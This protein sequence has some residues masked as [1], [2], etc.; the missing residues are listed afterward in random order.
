MGM[1]GEEKVSRYQGIRVSEEGSPAKKN[2]LKKSGQ[3][4]LRLA[5]TILQNLLQAAP[6]RKKNFGRVISSIY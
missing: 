3:N 6:K 4:I 2:F 1:G 5:Y